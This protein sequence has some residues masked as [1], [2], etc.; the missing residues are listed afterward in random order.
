[1]RILQDTL[2]DEGTALTLSIHRIQCSGVPSNTSVSIKIMQEIQ[3]RTCI[4]RFLSAMDAGAV[5]FSI[6]ECCG[7]A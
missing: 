7:P 5:G 1:M 4:S 6:G 2:E 3:L